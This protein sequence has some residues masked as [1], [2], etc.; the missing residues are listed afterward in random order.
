MVC[1]SGCMC[2]CACVFL[3]AYVTVCVY[4]HM[5]ACVCVCVCLCEFMHKWICLYLK[6]LLSIS[7]HYNEYEYKSVKHLKC[8]F[9]WHD[10]VYAPV[11]S[12]LFLIECNTLLIVINKTNSP[13]ISFISRY[14][15]FI[16]SAANVYELHCALFTPSPVQCIYIDN[17]HIRYI[18]PGLWH[19]K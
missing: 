11:K 6:K 18:L 3:Y 19:S 14:L 4:V 15:L 13:G 7:M 5:W 2:M 10:C 1:V 9:I 16:F 12:L 17:T 8:P